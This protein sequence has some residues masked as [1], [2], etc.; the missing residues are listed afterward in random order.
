VHVE[1]FKSF[2]KICY[3]S[4]KIKRLHG[5]SLWGELIEEI[6]KRI[7]II[8]IVLK[9]V[10]VGNGNEYE[11]SIKKLNGSTTFWE[12]HP[13]GFCLF[14]RLLHGDFLLPYRL[15]GLKNYDKSHIIV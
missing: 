15:K 5:G 7:A 3:D 14:W 13:L 12:V 6:N 2:W 10:V 8:Y 11:T 9:G 4:N 1:K